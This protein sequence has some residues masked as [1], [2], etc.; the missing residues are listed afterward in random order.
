MTHSALRLEPTDN[1]TFIITGRGKEGN[2]SYKLEQAR[3][4]ERQGDFERACNERFRAFQEIYAILPE[5][6]SIELDRSHANTRAAMEIIHDSAID[7]FFAGDAE[8]AA[9]QAELLLDCDSEDW[10]DTTQILALCYVALGDTDCLEETLMDIDDK[11]PLKAL[12][13]AWLSFARNGAIGDSAA[14]HLQ[15]HRAFVAELHA[16]AHP[17]DEA[18]LRDISSDRPSQQAAARE[19]WLRCEPIFAAQPDFAHALKAAVG[20]PQ[21]T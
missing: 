11:S 21:R 4:A 19:L 6:E 15:R 9:A 10:L 14:E 8:L 16:E 18:Y 12:L 17:T 5:E 13:D 20:K 7:N 3:E 2:L 1:Q